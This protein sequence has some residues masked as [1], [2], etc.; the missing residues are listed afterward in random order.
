M[1]ATMNT[2][3]AICDKEDIYLF[4]VPESDFEHHG[5]HFGM[6]MNNGESNAVFIRD[7]LGKWEEL[8]VS[9]HEI[10]HI[11]MGHLMPNTSKPKAQQ[12]EEAKMFAASFLAL[13]MFKEY[14]GGVNE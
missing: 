6:A 1:T 11:V 5:R 10:A 2:I 4:Y 7:K 9:A 3:R 14:G 8:H 13:S 12:E